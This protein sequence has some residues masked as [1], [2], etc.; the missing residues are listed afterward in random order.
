MKA[1]LHLACVLNGAWLA[2]AAV[3]VTL[4]WLSPVALAGAALLG[5][6]DSSA[7]MLA[8]PLLPSMEAA[9]LCAMTRMQAAW[10]NAHG[11]QQR[12]AMLAVLLPL[13]RDVAE[14]IARDVCQGMRWR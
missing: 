12:L 1:G 3:V 14:L 11:L 5:V 13:P 9:T 6:H 4:A 8:A 2:V 7:R 10:R